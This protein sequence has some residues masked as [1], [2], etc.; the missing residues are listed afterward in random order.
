MK[1]NHGI[2]IGGQD[3]GGMT[4][5][6]GE[7][8]GGDGDMREEVEMRGQGEAGERGEGEGL[9]QGSK[10][11]GRRRGRWGKWELGKTAGRE[12]TEQRGRELGGEGKRKDMERG[13]IGTRRE[14]DT[15]GGRG[16]AEE[17]NGRDGDGRKGV[18]RE[19]W[20]GGAETEHGRGQEQYMTENTIIEA[21]A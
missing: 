12:G 15:A 9:A 5:R 6:S 16:K 21:A 20:Q 8:G 4:G 7:S 10:A 13:G 1:R 14:E 2:G 3:W 18:R 17:G 11:A 19:R